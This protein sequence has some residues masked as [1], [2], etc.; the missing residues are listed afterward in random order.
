LICLTQKQ[1]INFSVAA[2]KVMPEMIRTANHDAL[3]VVR[4]LNLEQESDADAL[5]K[6]VDEV[7]ETLSEKVTE[8]K[9]GKKGLLGLFM[10]EVKKRSG[11]KA[12]PRIVNELLIKK[13]GS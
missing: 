8:Y 2:G 9:K 3:H 11:G 13:L 7:L 6:F 12:D 10:G 4:E 1:L 5:E